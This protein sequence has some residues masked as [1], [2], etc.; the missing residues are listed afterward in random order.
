M[1]YTARVLVVADDPSASEA[2]AHAVEGL[3]DLHFAAGCETA[4]EAMKQNP[5]DLVLLDADTADGDGLAACRILRQE[6][7]RTAVIFVTSIGEEGLEIEALSA[8]AVDCIRKPISPPVVRARVGVHLRLAALGAELNALGG[9]DPLTGVANRRTLDERLNV[10]WCR[11]ARQWQALGL[12]AIDIDYLERY[13]ER[14]GRPQGDDC[15]RRVAQFISATVVRAGDLV[16]LYDGGA[17]AAL[18]PGSTLKNAVALGEKL[19]CGVRALAIPHEGSDA[20]PHVTV[21]IG[22]ASMLPPI[23]PHGI[24]SAPKEPAD[25]AD[26]GQSLA[27]ELLDRAREALRAA[28]A[29][30]RDRVCAD[31]SEPEAETSSFL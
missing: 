21:S 23:Q 27:Q 14:Y 19:A 18:L 10:E 25:R 22:A 5:I 31:P 4:A 11:A 17:F 29:E 1:T 2:L 28:K 6:F 3:G 15:L 9:R 8:G 20:A 12:L 30:G 24:G 7:P 26:S 13:N 16:A